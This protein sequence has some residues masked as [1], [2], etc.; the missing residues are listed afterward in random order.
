MA[1][2][3][4][5]VEEFTKAVKES[6]SYRQVMEKLGIVPAGGNYSTV[7]RRVRK[8]NIDISHF[9]GHAWNKGR[10]FPQRTKDI[11]DYLSNKVSILSFKLKKRLLSDKILEHRCFNC[12]LEKWLENYIPLELHHIDGNS[13]NNEL[14]NL[15]LL[16]PNCHAL[17]Q[18]YRGKN[19]KKK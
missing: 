14:C 6:L 7:R 1:K 16:C 3:R 19:K 13:D 18:N 8:L 2:Y 15:Q 11:Q 4:H 17:T 9:T 12:H 5:S 10:K